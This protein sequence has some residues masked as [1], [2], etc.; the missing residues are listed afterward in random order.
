MFIEAG[1]TEVET[2]TLAQHFSVSFI[3][4]SLQLFPGRGN[5]SG[6]E[7]LASRSSLVYAS[8]IE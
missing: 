8:Y 2:A 3:D 4:A 1:K 5:K 7:A 6:T